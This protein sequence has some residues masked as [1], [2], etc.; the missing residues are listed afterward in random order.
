MQTFR[1]FVTARSLN[2]LKEFRNYTYAQDKDGRWLN[3]PIDAYNHAIDA[4]RYVV[5]SELMSVPR[6]KF[7]LTII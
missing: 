4:V 1:I 3:I 7:R 6:G 2:V 5:M